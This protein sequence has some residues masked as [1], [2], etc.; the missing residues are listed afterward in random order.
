MT[1]D[2]RYLQGLPRA[3]RSAYLSGFSVLCVQEVPCTLYCHCEG[4]N[5]CLFAVRAWAKGIIT[6]VAKWARKPRALV[7][8]GPQPNVRY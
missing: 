6:C 7:H 2:P 4:P 3:N 5:E 8:G 1:P